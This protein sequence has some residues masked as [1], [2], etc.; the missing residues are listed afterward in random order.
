MLYK[1]GLISVIIPFYNTEKYIFECLKSI[2]DQS[3]LSFEVICVDDESTDGST[4]IV[5]QFIANDSR[6]RSIR[7]QKSNAGEARNVGIDNASGE[8]IIFLD[9]DDFFERDLL[10]RAHDTIEREESD[11]CIFGVD[12]Y[13]ESLKEYVHAYPLSIK[14]FG[15]ERPIEISKYRDYAQLVNRDVPWDRLYRTEYIK[16]NNLKFQSIERCNDTSFAF[17]ATLLADKVS[18]IDDILLHHRKGHGGNLQAGISNTPLIYA[19][20]ALYTMK[21]MNRLD[22]NRVADFSTLDYTIRRIITNS[23][24][25]HTDEY[26]DMLKAYLNSEIT[27]DSVFVKYLFDELDKCIEDNNYPF[28]KGVVLLRHIHELLQMDSCNSLSS[29]MSTELEHKID[30]VKN[31]ILPIYKA[32]LSA[33]ELGCKKKRIAI[34]GVGKHTD[35]MLIAY[36]ELLGNIEAKVLFC[37]TSQEEEQIYEG[38]RVLS[39]KELPEEL[40]G[41]IISSF[42]YRSAM[43]EMLEECHVRA[44]IIDVYETYKVDLFSWYTGFCHEDQEAVADVQISEQHDFS[45]II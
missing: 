40:D 28:E 21:E 37:V 25:F 23:V 2:A 8:F 29:K 12:V 15:L 36:S 24:I 6:F 45:T 27:D 26:I 19:Q 9:S 22:V 35:G 43:R 11:Y 31:K 41:I 33:T 38:E 5:K 44:S 18:V 4:S 20:T 1:D 17:C 3:Y 39:I 14:Q 42:E 32:V 10:K 16:T 13:D 30:L 34:Y 7:I